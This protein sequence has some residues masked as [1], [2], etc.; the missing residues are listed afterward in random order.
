MKI[1]F[2]LSLKVLKV[3]RCAAKVTYQTAFREKFNRMFLQVSV[4]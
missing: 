4:N 3:L 1:I 2:L